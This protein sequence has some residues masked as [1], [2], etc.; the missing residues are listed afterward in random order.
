M[1]DALQLLNW[2]LELGVDENVGN[3]PLNRFS[4][5]PQN[6]E[7]KIQSSISAEQKIP[8]T[9]RAITEAESRAERSKTLDQLK[10]SLAEY[11]FC[12]L[13]KGSRNLVFSSGDPNAK[14]MIVGEAPGREEDIQGVPFV[15]RAGQL[16]DKMLRPIGLTRNK[17]QLNN[18]LIATAYICNV[19]PW[20]PP[21]NRDPNSDEIEMM[22]PFLKKHISLVQPKIIVALGNI[23]CRAL[24]GRTGITKLRGNWFDFDK[25]P[26]MP[27]CHPAYLLRNNAAKK[28]AWSDLLQIKKKLGD[29]A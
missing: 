4:E 6:D 10:S 3:V 16:L 5:L 1:T 21:Y 18:S 25:I 8:N 11:E 29:V 7:I 22:L 12:D 19:I 27:M 15:G 28:D 26:L 17:N 23:S 20:R 9:N 13:K 24:I 2:Q 14:V